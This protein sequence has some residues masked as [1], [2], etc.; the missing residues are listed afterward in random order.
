MS[1][2]CQVSPIL[3]HGEMTQVNV[4]KKPSFKSAVLYIACNINIVD[5]FNKLKGEENT[6]LT[7][8]QEGNSGRSLYH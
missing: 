7:K 4:L 6:I 8:K 1:E 3:R 2:Y 5:V